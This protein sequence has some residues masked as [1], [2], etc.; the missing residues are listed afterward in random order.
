MAI[1]TVAGFVEA[2]RQTRLLDLDQLE[3]LA[4]VQAR[5]P[6]PRALAKILIN[7]SWLTPYQ[8]NEIF[9]GQSA[10]LVLGQY[11]V[12][13][14]L[15]EGGMGQVFKARHAAMGRIVALKV[16]RKERL[17]NAE[18]V[19]RF[20]REVRAAAQLTHPNIV[21]AFDADQIN[22]THY[23]AMEFV[24]GID[25]AQLV[26]DKGPLSV[27]RACECIRQAAH[28][29]QFAHERGMV[30]RDIKPANLLLGIAETNGTPRPADGKKRGKPL[31][32]ILDMG[33]A[34]VD[35][36][37]QEEESVTALSVDGKVMGTPD[38]MAPEQAK[39]SH[40]VDHRADIYSLGCTFYF[41]LTKQPLFPGG[42]Q[43]E[44]FIKHQMDAPPSVRALRP[45]VSEGVQQI[46]SRMLA[47]RPE[48]RFQ[49]AAEVAAALAPFGDPNPK[50]EPQHAIRAAAAGSGKMPVM[51]GPA[52]A[53]AAAAP[54]TAVASRATPKSALLSTTAALPRRLRGRSK[55][56]V[57]AALALL[58]LGGVLLAA[59]AMMSSS[60]SKES[61][62]AV[63]SAA[64]TTPA[65]TSA[66]PP[67][68]SKTSA[69]GWTPTGK[70][71]VFPVD[72]PGPLGLVRYLPDNTDLVAMLHVPEI[73]RSQFY[74]QHPDL[75]KKPLTDLKA[76][77]GSLSID[78]EKDIHR[79]AIAHVGSGRK[80]DW[81]AVVMG[82]FDAERVRELITSQ[83]PES[84]QVRGMQGLAGT[85]YLLRKAEDGSVSYGA[86]LGQSVL[87]LA[88]EESTLSAVM[89]RGATRKIDLKDRELLRLLERPSGKNQALQLAMS[90]NI[91]ILGELTIQQIF[92]LRSVHAF[93]YLTDTASFRCV[94]QCRDAQTAQDLQ[95]NLMK[96]LRDEAK[97]NPDLD[98][99]AQIAKTFNFII[100]DDKQ[101]VIIEHTFTNA[102]IDR[103]FKGGKGR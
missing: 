100:G 39:D 98:Q 46:L 55:P 67:T 48:E 33:L 72:P 19:K 94:C 31:V 73:F 41:L 81:F 9:R 71:P 16:I 59:W 87:A 2:L 44:K 62:P 15:G 52:M 26:K 66:A 97:K 61:T 54:E 74:R 45:E 35:S 86:V 95:A 28:G 30:H 22:G 77:L 70:R 50:G 25:L 89:E 83:K 43:L 23:L 102:E 36:P 84:R 8:V 51:A 60:S 3:E 56:M 24:E 64:G 58:V 92:G 29:L 11:R 57:F 75:M 32:K 49:S 18:A 38:F 69:S 93:L 68:T 42:N 103:M 13:E 12:L 76:V 65:T 5:T 37:E 85:Y 6:D 1:D 14:R 20:Q 4:R 34:R 82:G 40:K 88:G 80:D 27:P 91:P 21:M 53:V 47:K 101:S 78:I 90:G 99:A 79:V 17:E 96:I 7:K 10:G 63:A